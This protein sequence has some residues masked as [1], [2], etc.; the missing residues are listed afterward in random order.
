M[1]AASHPWQD[2]DDFGFP[3]TGPPV[4]DNLDIRDMDALQEILDDFKN[5]TNNMPEADLIGLSPIQVHQCLYDPFTETENIVG[6]NSNIDTSLL[7]QAPVVD[8]AQ[9]LLKSLAE[10]EPLRATQ[11]GNLPRKFSAKMSEYI[12]PPELTKYYSIKSEEDSRSLSVLRYI[13]TNAG[14]MKMANKK[15]SLTR[16]GRE[17]V[18]KGLP[19]DVYIDLI[20]SY[21]G[22]F[23]WR[24]GDRLPEFK[25]IQL[26]FLLSLF[27]LHKK[28]GSFISTNDIG[29][30]FVAAFPDVTNEV[31]ESL[32]KLWGID[33]VVKRAFISRF[34]ER[35]CHWFG[36]VEFKGKKPS[37]AVS[38][39]YSVR[40]TPLFKAVFDWK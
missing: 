19:W 21:C 24:Y 35:F 37:P 14:L 12:D 40:T 38:H 27:M 9:F 11:K 30:I 20:K 39:D 8:H 36:L 34:I 10:C 22:R 28:T 4:T 1:E 17:T 2:N 23:D 18:S 26:S 25:I 3:S 32:A 6:F 15:F 16:R 5:E 31:P 33:G 29:D 13:A 7:A